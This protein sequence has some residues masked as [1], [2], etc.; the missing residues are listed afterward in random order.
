MNNLNNHTAIIT[1]ASKGIGKSIAFKLA[2]NG[3]DLILLSRTKSLLKVVKNQIL[4]KFNV[5]VSYHIADTGDF[6]SINKLFSEITA[7]NE[8][9]DILVNNAGVTKDNILARMS[10]EDWDSVINTNLKGYFNCCKAVIKQM[11]KQK[12][13]RI[14]NISSIIG[15]NGN[16]GQINYAA[17][18]SGIIGL[19]KSLSKEVGSRNITV[20]AIAPGFIQTEMT[21]KLSQKDKDSFLKSI[22]LKRFGK[23]EDIANLVS[24]LASDKA[25]YIT[26]QIIKIDGGIN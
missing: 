8:R 19:T 15:L 4:D 13:G 1:G 22:A 7:N 18:K 25:A 5:K 17:S 21:D 16:S 10:E 14:I 6:K 23:S 3:A 12:F 24:F 2:E 26:G 9:V 11:M 20:N